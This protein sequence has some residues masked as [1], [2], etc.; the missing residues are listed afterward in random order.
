[1]RGVSLT[2][3]SPPRERLAIRLFYDLETGELVS[4]EDFKNG[5]GIWHKNEKG[6]VV[7]REQAII[8][9]FFIFDKKG[10]LEGMQIT[11]YLAV[12]G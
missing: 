9:F 11:D 12:A 8:F 5:V 7:Q 3:L 6:K 10:L 4:D 2:R 1:M